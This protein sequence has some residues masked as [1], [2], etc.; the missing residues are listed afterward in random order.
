M[1]WAPSACLQLISNNNQSDSAK[2]K[3]IIT[4]G[5]GT[6][7]GT[8]TAK[9]FT[10]AGA[11]HVGILIRREKPLLTTK[12][13]IKAEFLSTKVTISTEVTKTSEVEAAFTQIA[14]KGNSK[15]D[16]LC[17]NAAVIKPLSNISALKVDQCTKDGRII[18]V[19]S[20]TAHLTIA[21]RFS[22]YNPSKMAITRFYQCVQFKN[23]E[24]S[25]F[26]LASP[27]DVDEL[28]ARQKEIKTTQFLS[29]GLNGWP[30]QG[31]D[32]SQS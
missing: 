12:A 16:I 6:G 14:G 29:G 17:S 2:G 4:T 5:G 1:G 24:F 19:N 30:F 9:Y 18:G 31:T 15:I 25:I 27:E 3:T 7:I 23:P 8:E 28:K 22:T 26:S 13:A 32:K 10:K 20:A 21:P 11:S